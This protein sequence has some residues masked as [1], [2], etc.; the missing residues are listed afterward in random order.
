MGRGGG[1]E[2]LSDDVATKKGNKGIARDFL[3]SPAREKGA[4][5]LFSISRRAFLCRARVVVTRPFRVAAWE[6]K[7]KATSRRL[8]LADDELCWILWLFDVTRYF[9]GI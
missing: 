6:F 5:P 7:M 2:R 1:G 4:A 9:H 3:T 8:D